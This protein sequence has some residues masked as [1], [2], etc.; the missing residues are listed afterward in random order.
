MARGIWLDK[1]S[2][3]RQKLQDENNFKSSFQ[4]VLSFSLLCSHGGYIL[5][6]WARNV[7]F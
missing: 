7:A 2:R 1:N 5:L 6:F 3:L 4:C